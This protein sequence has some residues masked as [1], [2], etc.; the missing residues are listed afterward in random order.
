MAAGYNQLILRWKDVNGLFN[1]NFFCTQNQNPFVNADLQNFAAA[2]QSISNCGLQFIQ[3]QQTIQI[4]NA[5]V[6]DS[7]CTIYDRAMF[8]D[9]TA[10]PLAYGQMQIPGL[11][12]AI[13]MPDNVTINL[14]NANVIAFVNAATAA[15][16]LPVGQPLVAVYSGQRTRVRTNQA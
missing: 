8:L 4:G 5:P 11:K 3:F 13:L 1:T 10:N 15:L 9:R 6:N 16:A 12:P 2:A 7:Y 14:N